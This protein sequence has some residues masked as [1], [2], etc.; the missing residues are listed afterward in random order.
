MI[1]SFLS[2]ASLDEEVHLY[3][4]LCPS[5]TRN[6]KCTVL[7]RYGTISSLSI[8]WLEIGARSKPHHAYLA[9]EVFCEREKKKLQKLQK[10]LQKRIDQE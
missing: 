6:A 3:L 8:V 1:S 9:S 4:F 10:K 2:D 5:E 7:D